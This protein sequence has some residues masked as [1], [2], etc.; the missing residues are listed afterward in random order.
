MLSTNEFDIPRGVCQI[1]ITRNSTSLLN[2]SEISIS[3]CSSCVRR[4]RTVLRMKAHTSG[5]RVLEKYHFSLKVWIKPMTFKKTSPFVV[6]KKIGTVD[7]LR[8]NGIREHTPTN[9]FFISENFIKAEFSLG[10]INSFS[11]RG[12]FYPSLVE[13]TG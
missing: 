9:Q 3:T 2:S 7:H 12:I 11:F 10:E 8:A 13:T 4:A 6:S 5:I 1:R